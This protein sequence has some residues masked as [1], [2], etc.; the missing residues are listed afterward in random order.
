MD[1]DQFMWQSIPIGGFDIS[2]VQYAALFPDLSAMDDR[3]AM[4]HYRN[5][6]KAEIQAKLRLPDRD[7]LGTVMVQQ[8]S[9]SPQARPSPFI[10]YRTAHSTSEW[11]TVIFSH[12]FV[13]EGKFAMRHVFADAPGALLFFNTRD[14]DWYQRG[15]PEFADNIASLTQ[16]IRRIMAR[17]GHEKLRCIGSSM[18]AYAAIAVGRRANADEVIAADP[19]IEIGHPFFRS[20]E[21]NRA[22]I[23]DPEAA[24]LAADIAI[25]RD[26]LT[27]FIAGSDPMEAANVGHLL[28]M[29]ERF[30]LV[31]CAH[32]E[33]FAMFMDW[34][35]YIAAPENGAL[36]VLQSGARGKV[37]SREHYARLARVFLLSM[38]REYPAALE[39]TN[40]LLPDEPW[41]HL[42]ATVLCYLVGNHHDAFAHLGASSHRS[43]ERTGKTSV[44]IIMEC[45][46]R[47]A[48][49]H[50]EEQS[51]LDF[52][53]FYHRTPK[54]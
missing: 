47:F 37:R 49:N 17:F 38:T 35:A 7:R 26:R 2:P 33:T 54:N 41:L 29:G 15:I 53:R 14:N 28:E 20:L 6:G 16:V 48:L 23:F 13:P 1:A 51:V 11:L 3:Q 32:G 19:E 5:H 50:K 27:L 18:G 40:A 4:E 46:E 30:T 42:Y 12:T 8:L 22:R 52:F 43:F 24:D 9:R 21:W 45:R 31:E 25:L 39:L 34:P 44:S 36:A 10:Q